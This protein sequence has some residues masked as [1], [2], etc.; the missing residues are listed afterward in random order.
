MESGGATVFTEVKTRVRPVKGSAAF[1]YNLLPN[2]NGNP[3]TKH[4]GCPVLSESKW[5]IDTIYSRTI[6]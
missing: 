4:A 3:R 1:W 2:G 6:K 5:G